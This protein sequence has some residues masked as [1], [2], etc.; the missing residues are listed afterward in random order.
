MY[1]VLIN[2]LTIMSSKP[3]YPHISGLRGLAIILVIL[4]HLNS[5]CFPHGFYGV[6]I[7][8]VISGYL[9]FLSASH[10][11]YQLNLKEFAAKKLFRIF[12][13]MIVTILITMAAAIVFLDGDTLINA[14]RTG[15]YALFCY[16]NNFLLR[17]QADYF[18]ADALENPLLHMW[19]LSVTI[20]LYLMFAIGCVVYRYI[21]RVL[22]HCLL[23]LIGIASFAYGYSYQ[24]CEILRNMDL[25]AWSQFTATSHYLTL[26]RVWEILAGGAILILPATNK[27][28]IATIL[29]LVGLIGILFSSLSADIIA[30][31]GAPAV[32]LGT[33]L[34]IR[35][36]PSSILMPILSNKL[37]LWLGGISFSLYL[38]HM[39]IIAFFLISY[40]KISSWSDY[41]TIIGLTLV[42]SWLFWFLV[43]KRKPKAYISIALWVI[44]MI[45]CVL[46]KKLDN[47]KNEMHPEVQAIKHTPYDDWQVCEE[48]VLSDGRDPDHLKYTD[49]LF[50]I[51]RSTKARPITKTPLMQIGPASS[52]PKLVLLGDSH[53]HSAYFGLNRLCHELN[54]PG[55]FLTTTVIPMWDYRLQV[56]D[57][58]CN[59]EAKA[60]ALINW[61]KANPCVTHVVIAQFWMLR[62]NNKTFTH[63]N[64]KTERM[65]HELMHQSLREFVKRIHALDRHVVL[66]GPTPEPTCSNP[67]RYIRNATRKGQNPIDLTPLTCT[68]QEIEQRNKDIIAIMKS[69][70]AEGL[71][72]VL[73]TISIIP[74]DKPFVAYKDGK[75]LM[76]DDDHLSGEGS[77]AL[78]QHLKPQVEAII[79]Q[80]MPS[81]QGDK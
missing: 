51:A 34:I 1:T 18:A 8:L 46:G 60:E 14:S 66:L 3:F 6:D 61:L 65:T 73:D 15:R 59:N 5:T 27:K 38:V 32:V 68:R 13:P 57:I 30:S 10:S 50:N 7:F 79:Q 31:Y 52:T 67:L 72:S 80:R 63:W 64:D 17:T 78:F 43:E 37:L 49:A 36:M 76:L 47:I 45:L 21:P 35:Y 11:N 81:R 74:D 56:T 55:A 77:T 4:F 70:Q 26:P 20:H 58:Y 19:Y 44:C 39:P 12:P 28:A 2:A 71:C 29:T 53:A 16:A 25:P 69:I 24:L 62:H 22:S 54:C 40:Q 9:L 23:W 42:I 75:F 41:A 33:M 48:N